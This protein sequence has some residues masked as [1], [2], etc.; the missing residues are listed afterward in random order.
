LTGQYLRTIVVSDSPD[1]VRAACERIEREPGLIVV[2]TAESGF[3]S[4]IAVDVLSPDLVLIDVARPG[5]DGLEATRRIKARPKPPAVVL[6]T[7]LDPAGIAER[8]QEVGADAV[9]S[10]RALGESAA[11]ILHALGAR[12]EFVSEAGSP[13]SGDR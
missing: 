11:C 7:L 10:K 8:A 1:F 13:G 12:P 3:A 4:L 9:I 5:S 6:I 2:A